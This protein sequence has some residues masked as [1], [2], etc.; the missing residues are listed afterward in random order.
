MVSNPA[1]N[2]A[3]A[4]IVAGLQMRNQNSNAF[5]MKKATLSWRSLMFK[6][7]KN[8]Y[9]TFSIS[10]NIVLVFALCV[11]YYIYEHKRFG[12]DWP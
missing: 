4:I 2:I 10:C 8:F 6:I 12:G 11:V 9:S 7:N 5:N 3:I 1:I